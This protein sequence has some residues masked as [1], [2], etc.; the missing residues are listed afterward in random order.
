MSR[1]I[2]LDG[3]YFIDLDKYNWI[4]KKLVSVAPTL[5]DGTPS[6][7]AGKKREATLGYCSSLAS[8]LRMYADNLEKDGVIKSSE[9]VSIAELQ[10][11]LLR[12]ERLCKSMRLVETE[13]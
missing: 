4:F 8:A 6:K 11:I 12:I 7:N 2:D 3:T 5:K 1:R 9:A 10:T 13:E